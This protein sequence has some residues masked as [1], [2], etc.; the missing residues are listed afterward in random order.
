[1][2][3]ERLKIEDIQLVW[4][5]LSGISSDIS[6]PL[7]RLKVKQGNEDQQVLAEC[8][9]A[10]IRVNPENSI[11]FLER[12]LDTDGLSELDNRAVILAE[13]AAL[14]I[15]ESK[16]EKALEILQRHHEESMNSDF[17]NMLLMPMAL[18]RLEGAFDYL[19]DIIEK[20]HSQSAVSAI[21]AI[22]RLYAQPAGFCGPM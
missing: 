4:K 8:L 14:A 7:L 22:I 2:R 18:T 9:Y 16:L 21:N 10:L 17:Q 1:M 5:A 12:F 19:I 15:G 20:G 13:N 6:E 3:T 11:G